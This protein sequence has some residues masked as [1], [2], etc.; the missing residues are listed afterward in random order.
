MAVL[1]I[2]CTFHWA[3][4]CMISAMKIKCYEK[5]SSPKIR[6]TQFFH[7]MNRNNNSQQPNRTHGV[8]VRYFR[9]FSGETLVDDA[10]QISQQSLSMSFIW[11]PALNPNICVSINTST[12]LRP[13]RL[14]AERTVYLSPLLT[15]YV[16]SYLIRWLF[17]LSFIRSPR[18]ETRH[19]ILC[20]IY[21]VPNTRQNQKVIFLLAPVK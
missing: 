11:N 17:F 5:Q 4:I 10:K 21:S 15:A 19:P 7:S 1:V 13:P 8:F 6:S 2:S 18:R 20:F 12:L 14:S 16:T 9:L 3:K